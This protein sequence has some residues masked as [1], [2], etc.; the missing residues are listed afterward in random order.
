L[1]RAHPRHAGDLNRF[2][3]DP[4]NSFRLS[5]IPPLAQD[6]INSEEGALIGRHRMPLLLSVS[7]DL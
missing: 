3:G 5:R 2:G 7:S 1:P 4:E 6:A